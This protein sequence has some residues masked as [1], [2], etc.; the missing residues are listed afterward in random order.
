M[1]LDP[2]YLSVDVSL[3]SFWW[4]CG[5]ELEAEEFQGTPCSIEVLVTDNYYGVTTY[6]PFTSAGNTAGGLYKEYDW[7]MTKAVMPSGVQGTEW[8][9]VVTSSGGRDGRVYIDNLVMYGNDPSC[10]SS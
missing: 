2:A 9:F 3:E 7:N 10:A 1:T 6:G 4:A 5:T 8:W